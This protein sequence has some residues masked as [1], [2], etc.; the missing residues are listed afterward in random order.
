MNEDNKIIDYVTYVST[1]LSRFY[2]STWD[3]SSYSL[4]GLQCDHT[5]DHSLQNCINS[6]EDPVNGI[7]LCKDKIY[8]FYVENTCESRLYMSY[9][10]TWTTWASSNA[11]LRAIC[12]TPSF[13]IGLR[14]H[15]EYTTV[16]PTVTSFKA[17]LK[18]NS[19]ISYE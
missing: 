18:I 15:V 9:L 1:V 19:K 5:W 17:F 13:W 12:T 7:D 14:E 11:F 6:E 10:T 2:K 8:E 4:M 16:P 3:P